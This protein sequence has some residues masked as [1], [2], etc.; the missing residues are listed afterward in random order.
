LSIVAYSQA[1]WSIACALLAELCCEPALRRSQRPAVALDGLARS[2][3]A[4]SQASAPAWKH[5][6]S[7][8][9]DLKYP[10]DFKQFDYVNANAPKGGAVRQMAFGTFDNFNLVVAGVK[11]SLVAGIDLVYDTLMVSALDEV[12]TEYGLLAEAVSHPADFAFVVYRLRANAKW[13]DGKPVTVEDVIF[14]F[15]AFKKNHPQLSAYY[16]HVTKAEKTGEREITFTFDG[17]GNRELPQ[18]VGQLN[19]LPKHWWEGTDKAGNRRDVAATTLEPPLGCGAYRLREFVPGRTVIFERVANYWGKDLAVNIGRDN[20]NEVRYEYFRDSTVA[21]EAFKADAIDWRTENS[22]KNWATAYDFPAVKDRRVLKEEFPILSSG[23]MQSFRLQ[24]PPAEIC[25]SARAPRLQLRAQFRRDERQMFFGQ[26]KRVKSYFEGYGACLERIA[27]RARSSRS[28]KPCATRCRRRCS[29]RLQQSGQRR[30]T[31]CARTCAR[32]HRL[33]RE[34]GYEIRDQKLVNA[35]T[36][37]ALT[38]E[39]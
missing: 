27:A 31:R 37:E 32:R 34:A 19:V 36:G 33:L 3:A 9:G 4:L 2:P 15:D 38:V 20:F 13:H 16:S 25:R 17:P 39:S 12:S 1:A 22:A 21:L 24:H 7:L 29:R 26:Y 30:R 14:S 10:A 28:W 5:G 18:I 6:L 35:K 8:F 11:G 23:G